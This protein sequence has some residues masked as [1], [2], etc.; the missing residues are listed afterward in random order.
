[1]A[2]ILRH[3]PALT[4]LCA[5]TVNA[6]KRLVPGLLAP[7][8][9]VWGHDNRTLYVRV[10]TERGAAARIEFRGGD[11]AANP[12]VLAAAVLAAALDGVEH[13]LDPPEPVGGDQS[14]AEAG[15]PLPRSLGEALDALEADTD[16]VARVGPELVRDFAV[17][18]RWELDRFQRWVTDWEVDEYSHHL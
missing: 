3:A 10:P 12:Y 6:Y 17:V 2:G 5:P 7:T 16:L 13:E 9:A 15:A 11:G 8:R 4:A 1:M 18:K 14:F